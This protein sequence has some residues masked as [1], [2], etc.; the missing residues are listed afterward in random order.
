[1][2]TGYERTWLLES[3]RVAMESLRD[4]I[5]SDEYDGSEELL[6]RGISYLLDE[7]AVRYGEVVD[8]EKEIRLGFEERLY[9]R[10]GSAFDVMEFYIM[11][12]TQAGRLFYVLNGIGDKG[13]NEDEEGAD[14]LLEAL[15]SLHIRA[16]QVSREVLALMRA[17]YA[18]GAF[19]RWRA[20]YEMAASAQFIAEHGEGT[21]NR[22]LNHKIVDDYYEAREYREH[23]EALGFEQMKDD[24][25]E[26]LEETF[27]ELVEE[28]GGAFKTS[29][30]WAAE[31]LD[32]DPSRRAVVDAVGLERYRPY[33]AFASDT[34][35]GGSKGAQF[36]LGLASSADE[37]YFLLAGPSNYG[38]TDPAQYTVLMLE[39][40]TE[41][42]L[43]TEDDFHWMVITTTIARLMEEVIGEFD[44][45][46]RILDA[47]IETAD[48]PTYNPDG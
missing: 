31:D 8:E 47:E 38:F 2:S 22:F 12:N 27:E 35:H 1:M 33:Y 14:P 17:G 18:D 32:E 30:G 10:W 13:E 7:L 21:A 3:V 39:E 19:S 6:S 44:R 26:T 34:V 16:C 41:A 11:L 46:R 9:W 20:L 29:Y 28:Y 36:R 5:E 43:S 45:Y 42:L 23:S 25:W 37:Q 24:E 48:D 15:V 40:V 4:D